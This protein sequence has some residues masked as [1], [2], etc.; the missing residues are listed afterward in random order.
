MMVYK[1]KLL[2]YDKVSTVN[3]PDG[4]TQTTICVSHKLVV[5]WDVIFAPLVV[6]VV[7]HY[8]H[9]KF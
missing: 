6:W 8:I 9:V 1:L 7:H 2:L 5:K 3:K 4:E